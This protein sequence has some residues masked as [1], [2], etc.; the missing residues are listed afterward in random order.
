MSV[1]NLPALLAPASVAVIGAT[2]RPGSVGA[3]V[4]RNLRGGGFRGRLA[5][6]NP[7][8]ASVAGMR[9]FPDVAA[10]DFVPDLAVVC[11]PAPSGPGIIGALGRLGTRAAIVLTAGLQRE[12]DAC[13]RTLAQAMLDEARPH[14]LR[15]LGPNCVGL[16]VP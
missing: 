2:D 8:H 4:M 15:I 9:A 11:T 5:P 1:R 16:L 12:R 6:V 3:T 7:R 14:L 10:L 13:G